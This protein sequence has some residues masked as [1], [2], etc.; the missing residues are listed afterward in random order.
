M[1]FAEEADML[2]G[3]ETG[4]LNAVSMLPMPKVVMLS[5]SSEFN[6]TRD[7]VN[8]V[9]LKSRGCPESPCHRMHYT[10]EF[11]PEDEETGASLCAAALKPQEVYDAI[12][13]G[14]GLRKIP[15]TEAKPAILQVNG[16]APAQ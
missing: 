10:R 1:A 8:T 15:K 7:W 16:G 13:S 12:V 6:L 2:V 4:M 5:H 14:L 9:A 11:C 3:P